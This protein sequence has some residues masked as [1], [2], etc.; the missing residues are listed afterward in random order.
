MV[1]ANKKKRAQR[2][3]GRQLRPLA[4][5]ASGPT[6]GGPDDTVIGWD[7]EACRFAPEGCDSAARQVVLCLDVIMAATRTDI[8]FMVAIACLCLRR[9]QDPSPIV[10]SAP[11]AV[12]AA[13]VA[14]APS[15]LSFNILATICSWDDDAIDGADFALSSTRATVLPSAAVSKRLRLIATCCACHF[16]QE[17]RRRRHAAVQ[18][19]TT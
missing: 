12:A 11:V 13:T 4:D 10:D 18:S 8:A 9:R 5:G 1:F 15:Q 3:R 7:R 6:G 14:S 17:S 19:A 16:N 2:R